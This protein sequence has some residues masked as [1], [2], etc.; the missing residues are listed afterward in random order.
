[1][2]DPVTS[3]RIAYFTGK[4]GW[5]ASNERHASLERALRAID[6]QVKAELAY[7]LTPIPRRSVAS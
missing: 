2:T 7:N 3:Y 6:T 4:R 5:L 1:M